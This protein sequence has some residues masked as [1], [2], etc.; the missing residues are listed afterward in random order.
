MVGQ[1]YTW[2]VQMHSEN[3]L[4]KTFLYLLIESSY[5]HYFFFKDTGPQVPTNVTHM[6][7][8]GS[9][10]LQAVGSFNGKLRSNSNSKHFGIY[11]F[12]IYP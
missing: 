1:L 12:R 9:N 11:Y 7:K 6:L 5:Q 8:L 3:D 4:Y 10:L 2:L